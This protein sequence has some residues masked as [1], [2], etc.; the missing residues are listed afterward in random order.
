MV[1]LELPMLPEGY[2]VKELVY[3]GVP[4]EMFFEFNMYAASQE[5]RVVLSN[6][7]ASLAGTVRNDDEKFVGG[8]K[9]MLARWPV[10]LGVSYPFDLVEATADGN[11]AFLFKGLRPGDYRVIAVA[12]D[13]R[14]VL[15]EPGRLLNALSLAGDTKLENAEALTCDP[16][17]I[18]P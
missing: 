13:R 1:Q 18:E 5:L 12:P 2:Y 14:P 3:N 11:G 17:L 16:K 10:M 9:V 4:V 15:E 7:A 6:G 8:A